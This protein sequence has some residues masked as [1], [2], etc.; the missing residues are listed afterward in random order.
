MLWQNTSEHQSLIEYFRYLWTH[1]TTAQAIASPT[2]FRIESLANIVGSPPKCDRLLDHHAF[3]K[4]LSDSLR[5]F[6]GEQVRIYTRN[7]QPLS[8]QL[9]LLTNSRI[10]Y[11]NY[12]VTRLQTKKIDNLHAK[13]I[14]IG[15]QVAYIGSQDFAFSHNPLIDLTYKTTNPEEIKIIRPL[16]ELISW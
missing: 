11:G 5:E 6:A 16:A 14:I 7:F 9:N 15:S 10:F 3:K 13:I 4:D 12:N 8:S 2:G 1:D